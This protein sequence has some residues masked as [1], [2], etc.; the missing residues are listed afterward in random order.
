MGFD[1]ILQY[2]SRAME[3]E[4]TQ[5]LLVGGWSLGAYGVNRQTIDIDFVVLERNLPQIEA[6]LLQLGYEQV[7]RNPLFAKFRATDGTGPDVDFLFLTEETLAKLRDDSVRVDIGKATFRVPSLRHL[8][9]MKLHALAHGRSRR[10]AK[11]LA[12]I[13][14]LVRANDI[15]VRSEEFRE[16]CSRYATADI[17]E[18]ILSHLQG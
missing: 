12:D 6:R 17:Y 5:A 1:Q 15:D 18:E 16:L 2:L 4:Q 11:D 8:I 7:F 14:A 13:E 9:G 10:G 3:Q